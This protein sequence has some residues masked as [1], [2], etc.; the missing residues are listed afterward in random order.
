MSSFPIALCVASQPPKGVFVN[1]LPVARKDDIATIE[2]DAGPILQGNPNIIV[3]G[4]PVARLGHFAQ[5]VKGKAGVVGPATSAPNVL[6]G[7]TSDPNLVYQKQDA[8][9]QP[10]QEATDGVNTGGV[11]RA[12]EAGLDCKSPQ[13]M[14]IGFGSKVAVDGKVGMVNSAGASAEPYV[15]LGEH[16]AGF[17]VSGGGKLDPKDIK[18]PK[19]PVEGK[20]GGFAEGKGSTSTTRVDAGVQVPDLD[21]EWEP[22][23]GTYA[24]SLGPVYFKVQIKPNAPESTGPASI[25]SIQRAP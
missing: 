16:S 3:N 24:V 4:K 10:V 5:G 15:T 20:F 22:Q 19:L 14:G 6:V 12:G 2:D 11:Y 7:P 23:K 18:K 21:A 17:H 25:S 1:A 9:C 8:A 13:F